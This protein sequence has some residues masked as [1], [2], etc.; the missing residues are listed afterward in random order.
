VTTQL[1][2]ATPDEVKLE[3]SSA[4]EVKLEVSSADEVTRDNP[5]RHLCVQ[6]LDRCCATWS[7]PTSSTAR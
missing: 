7:R 2:P 3:V 6:H 4:D 5:A 1:A